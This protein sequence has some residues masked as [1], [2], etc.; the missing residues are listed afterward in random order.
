MRGWSV[1]LLLA[2]VVGS[3]ATVA[4]ADQP[5]PSNPV[6]K[7]LGVVPVHG[8]AGHGFGSGSSLTYHNGPVM[9]TNKAYGI[10]WIPS[11]Y[12]VSSNYRSLIDGFFQNVAADS[13]KQGNVYYSDTQY[14]DTTGNVAYAS[15]F[16]GSS[17]DTNPFPANGC[18]DP[19]TSVCLTDAQLQSEI[20]S[21]ISA[22]G[23]P[24]GTGSVYFLFTPKNVGSCYGS[25]CAFSFCA[26]HSS[27][28]SGSN[29]V[30]YANQPYAAWVP[31]ACGS[32]QS[33][34][35]D[36]ADSSI[37]VVSHEHNESITDPLGSAWYDRRGYE[38]GDKCAWNFGS[39]IGGT[40][41]KYYN[42]LIGGGTYYLQ[43]EWSNKSSACVLTGT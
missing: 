34:N 17:V 36:D 15:T 7:I 22:K 33:P 1:L 32:G 42:Q 37:N 4:L 28:G 31:A 38:N 23:W 13:G 21:V 11:G 10:Y 18:S 5:S 9:R 14:Y 35:S 29:T 19:Y 3:G 20:S 40:N 2:V 30:L 25:S 6:G 27:F 24:R 43:Q 41:G 39:P 8:Q 16:S 12:S 26:Y